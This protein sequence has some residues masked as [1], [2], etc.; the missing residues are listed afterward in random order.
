MR[1]MVEVG[2]EEI[3][4]WSQASLCVCTTL[5]KVGVILG[6]NLVQTDASHP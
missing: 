2:G 6:P 5:H 3:A 1:K 4:A